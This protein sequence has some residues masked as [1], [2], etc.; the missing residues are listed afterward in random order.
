MAPS[1]SNPIAYARGFQKIYV[2]RIVRHSIDAP[3]HDAE[4][5][6]ISTVRIPP[7][8]T[9]GREDVLIAGS[10]AF[11]TGSDRNLTLH[12]SGM[13]VRNCDRLPLGTCRTA[14]PNRTAIDQTRPRGERHSFGR[15]Q[16]TS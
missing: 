4:E 13:A 11:Q 9:R 8:T 5:A 15:G 3:I 6:L 1:P 16:G 7:E 2:F 12:Y 14:N 10:F